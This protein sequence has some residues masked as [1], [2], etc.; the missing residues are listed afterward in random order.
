MN[1]KHLRMPSALD[2]GE[3]AGKLSGY[4]SP[5]VTGSFLRWEG[6]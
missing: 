2:T 6:S 5:G 3:K 4:I 1:V